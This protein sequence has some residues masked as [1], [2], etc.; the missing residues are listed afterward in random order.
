MLGALRE[1]PGPLGRGDSGAVQGAGIASSPE[2]YVPAATAPPCANGVRLRTRRGP[3]PTFH[4]A[5]R[6]CSGRRGQRAA[7]LARFHFRSPRYFAMTSS[8]PSRRYDCIGFPDLA[9]SSRRAVAQRTAAA[10]G[11]V[12]LIGVA[13][14]QD[15]VG[16]RSP[17]VEHRTAPTDSDALQ[18]EVWRHS[19]AFGKRCQEAG[20]GRMSLLHIQP[21]QSRRPQLARSLCHHSSVVTRTAPRIALTSLLISTCRN[22]H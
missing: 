13:D 12:A 18:V 9:L 5:C 10:A 11:Q 16:Q 8:T 3:P 17:P 4:S 15:R 7:F 1:A 22:L 6:Y 19:Y 14:R 20:I 21:H 2:P